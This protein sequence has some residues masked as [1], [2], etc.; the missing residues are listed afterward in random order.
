MSEQLSPRGKTRLGGGRSL[1]EILLNLEK[2]GWKSMGTALNTLVLGRKTTI[3][4]NHWAEVPHEEH[5]DTILYDGPKLVIKCPANPNGS[6]V[7]SSKPV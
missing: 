3:G 6:E 5:N 7:I 1:L 4:N 2:R